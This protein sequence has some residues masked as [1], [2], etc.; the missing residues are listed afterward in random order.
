M[1]FPFRRFTMN[2]LTIKDLSIT[3]Q[4]D[5][6]A[7]RA[8]R[9]GTPYELVARQLGHADVQMV[10]TRYGR[11]A[12]RSDERDRWEKIAAQ[13]DEPSPTK[14]EESAEKSAKMGAVLGAAPQDTSS[15]PP[16]SDWLVNS[17]G[18]T[19]THDPGIMSAVL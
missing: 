10:A 8:V 4:L 11:Y 12:P 7:I 13:L 18:G 6:K 5:S 1:P 2:T 9:G 17:R 16:L 15:Q 14:S 19:R 3:E